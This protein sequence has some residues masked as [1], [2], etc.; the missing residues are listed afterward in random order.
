MVTA[1][2]GRTANNRLERA[3][4]TPAAQPERWADMLDKATMVGSAVR[5]LASIAAETRT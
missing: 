3:G 2:G 5:E 4:S 1:G